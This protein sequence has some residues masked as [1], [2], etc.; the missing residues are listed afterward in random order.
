MSTEYKK[1]NR[2]S[3][4]GGLVRDAEISSDN[5]V[6]AFRVAQNL[7]STGKTIFHNCHMYVYGGKT[8]PTELLTRGSKVIIDGRLSLK[9]GESVIE[10]ENV[11][12]NQLQM[13]VQSNGNRKASLQRVNR[14]EI[15]GKVCDGVMVGRGG[16]V[17]RFHVIHK[18]DYL[19]F[20]N[21]TCVMFKPDDDGDLPMDL[22]KKDTP[23]VIT[24]R[25][26]LN[27]FRNPAG[28]VEVIVEKI[29]ENTEQ[30]EAPQA[31]AEEVPPT[32]LFPVQ[33]QEQTVPDE[34]ETESPNCTIEP[35][36]F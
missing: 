25:L 13:T 17:V 19:N 21:L 16:E 33:E 6:A 10:V 1:I 29:V 28:E 35:V 27:T 15:D 24:G 2:V 9:R 5:T 34:A 26:S 22:I 36:L 31:D 12:A 18:P 8:L 30:E 32:E 23:V 4:S 14:I 3:I 20:I 11:R 7:S